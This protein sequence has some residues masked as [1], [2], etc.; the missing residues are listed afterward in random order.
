MRAHG[1]ARLTR[2]TFAGFPDRMSTSGECRYEALDAGSVLRL[3]GVWRLATLRSVLDSLERCAPRSGV[4]APLTI[5]GSALD[6]IDTAGAFALWHALARSRVQ[7]GDVVLRDFSGSQRRI[8]EFVGERLAGIDLR[9]REIEA[10]AAGLDADG[11]APREIVGEPA[12]PRNRSSEREGFGSSAPGTGAGA[13][14]RGVAFAVGQGIV[15]IFR[16]VA[17][18]VEFLGRVTAALAQVLVRPRR[19]R[20]RELF[21]QLGQACV[22]AIPVIALVTFLIGLVVAYLLAQQATQYGANLFVIDGVAIGLSREFSP[23][24]VAVVLAGRSGAAFTAQ[25]GT[26][27]LTEEI[28]AIRTLGLSVEQV[29]VVPRVLALVL[30]MPLLVFVGDVVGLLGAMLI[31]R[32]MLDIGPELFLERLRYALAPR[33]FVIGLIK[34]PV[35]ASAIA[36]IACRMGLS[37]SRDA[38]SIGRNTTSTVVQ[39]IVVVIVLDALFA[40]LLQAIGL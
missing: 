38:R 13:A 16:L 39:S 30:A 33:H 7:P 23:L 18:N 5:D 22:T 25:L 40:V 28:D 14:T 15:S 24:I 3:S 17:G 19:L 4:A 9:R 36:V 2:A 11:E 34:A 1:C 10:A 8:V 35:F 29:L 26:M 27:R 12:K 6:E 20:V 37:V 32:D 31:A 21:A